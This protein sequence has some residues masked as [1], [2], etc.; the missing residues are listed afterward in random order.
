M[1]LPKKLVRTALRKSVVRKSQPSHHRIP[2]K[3]PDEDFPPS[4]KI[5]NV[6]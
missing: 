5:L 4:S 1:K 3:N 2:L 6:L